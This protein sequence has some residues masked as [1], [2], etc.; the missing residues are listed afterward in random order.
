MRTFTSASGK[1]AARK[2]AAIASA[3]LVTEPTESTVLIEISSL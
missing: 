3:A 1:P 2:R